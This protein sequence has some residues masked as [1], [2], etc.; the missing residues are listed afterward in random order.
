MSRIKKFRRPRKNVPEQKIIG[1]FCEGESEI[2]YFNML[3]RKY[4]SANV[5]AHKIRIK[6]FHGKKVW[7]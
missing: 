7:L 2:Q 4:H 5:N 1:I 3:K 6:Q